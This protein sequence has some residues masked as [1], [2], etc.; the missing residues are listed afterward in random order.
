MNKLY[1]LF[2]INVILYLNCSPQPNVNS[3][4]FFRSQYTSGKPYI[5]FSIYKE[6]KNKLG[7]EYIFNYTDL[8]G[9]GKGIMIV[10]EDSILIKAT[11]E[12]NTFDLFLHLTDTVMTKRWIEIQTQT[13]IDID[14]VQNNKIVKHTLSVMDILKREKEKIYVLN[15]NDMLYY[16]DTNGKI[17]SL[18]I[19]FSTY[20]GVIG[21]YYVDNKVPLNIYP[22]TIYSPR[23]DILSDI[24]DYSKV[25]KKSFK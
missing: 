22:S 13:L 4:D 15:I 9:A 11:Y 3:C 14:K 24:I 23:G 21:H 19:F 2:I 6:N 16:P 20:D 1:Y 18:I 12:K 17:Y 10:R 5:W 25:E 7:C 8:Y